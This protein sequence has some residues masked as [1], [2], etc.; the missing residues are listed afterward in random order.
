MTVPASETSITRHVG[1][2]VAATFDYEYKIT[3]DS[4]LLVTVTDLNDVSTVKVLA[5]DYTVTGVGGSSGSITLVAGALT[6]GYTLSIEDNVEVSQL[7]PYG[8]QGA[9]FGQLHEDSFDKNLRV[10][11]RAYTRS[12]RSLSLPA[13]IDGVAGSC[14][15]NISAPR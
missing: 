9:F 13:T 7:S 11:R 1:N 8:N 2:G 3:S 10:A 6:T 14:Y 5:T 4:D 15:T 12:L